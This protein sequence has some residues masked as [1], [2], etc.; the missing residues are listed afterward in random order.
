MGIEEY[1][2]LL[3]KL[4]ATEDEDAEIEAMW[5]AEI[6]ERYLSIKDGSVTCIPADDAMRRARER[7]RR[8]CASG[9]D[10]VNLL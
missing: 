6:E 2:N 7:I 9:A 1:E 3:S 10:Q 4:K 8:E 5:V